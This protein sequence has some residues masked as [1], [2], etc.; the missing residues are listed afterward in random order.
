[1]A[2]SDAFDLFFLAMAQYRRRRRDQ[3]LECFDRAVRWLRVQKN[4]SAQN[5]SEL[6]TFR[7]EAKAVLAGPATEL[8]AD[9][10]APPRSVVL[11]GVAGPS[12]FGRETAE[13]TFVAF[14]HVTVGPG[15]SL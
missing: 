14:R 1:V 3:A 15:N 7:T 5:S 10:F 9:G 8:P 6:A 2:K 4:L 13:A 12:R 11:H